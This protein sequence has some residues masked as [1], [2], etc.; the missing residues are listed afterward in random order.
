MTWQDVLDV[1]PGMNYGHISVF[2]RAARL[3]GYRFI[4][5]QQKVYFIVDDAEI[6]DTGVD[7]N[8]LNA[9]PA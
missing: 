9:L 5:W 2:A 7:I 8:E 3:L 4:A 1:K 6:I